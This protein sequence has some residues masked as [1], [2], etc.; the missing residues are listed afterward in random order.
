MTSAAAGAPRVSRGHIRAVG[1][2]TGLTAV[3]TGAL[4]LLATFLAPLAG[5]IPPQA[6]A[7]A[8]ILVGFLM[9][10]ALGHIDW[11]DPADALPALLTGVASLLWLALRPRGVG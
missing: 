11:Q 4:F 1:G 3:V 8:L 6:T 2:R 7:P 5:I 9:A 10:G